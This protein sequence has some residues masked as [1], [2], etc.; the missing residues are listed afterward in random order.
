MSVCRVFWFLDVFGA[1]DFPLKIVFKKFQNHIFFGF[2]AEIQ[3]WSSLLDSRHVFLA[4]VIWP[5]FTT[6]C[7]QIGLEWPH[8]CCY[9]LLLPT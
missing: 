1:F 6:R 4:N 9:A 7:L 5:Y 3:F 2:G 8:R